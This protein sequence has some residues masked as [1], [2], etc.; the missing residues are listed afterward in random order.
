MPIRIN[1]LAEQQEAEEQR[2]RDPA[3]RAVWVAGFVVGLLVVWAAYLQL[4]VLS[5]N[6]QVAG[7]EAK[8]KQ[9]EAKYNQVR[10]NQNQVVEIT[11]RIDAL[12]QLATNR[13]LWGTPLNALQ[14]AVVPNVHLVR[15]RTEQTHNVTDATKP[16]TNATGVIRGTPASAKETMLMKIDARDFSATPGEQIPR[17][18][19]VLNN[20]PCFQT[21]L[22]KAE[23][24]H[25]APPT[26]EPG[27]SS[28]PFVLFTVDCKYPERTR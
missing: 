18:L 21:N 15:V 19:E 4:R 28:G 20:H 13:F 6:S 3:K 10:T 9:L 25:R 24:A 23:L 11:R 22:M 17:Y 2:R 14:F 26:T 27:E 16:V 8:F 5:A 12:Q 1:L 7:V